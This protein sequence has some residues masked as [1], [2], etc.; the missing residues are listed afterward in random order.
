MTRPLP[1]ANLCAMRVKEV[2][3]SA[4]GIESDATL[5]DA[6]E[7]IQASGCEAVP[8]VEGS[9]GEVSVR[10]LVA[11]RDL[12]KLRRIEA[13]ASRGHAVGH[14]VLELLG[15]LG[16]RPGRFP[17]IEPEATLTDA[18]G[19]MSDECLTHLPVVEDGQV[20][21]M[22]SLV[23]TFAEFPHRSPAAGFWT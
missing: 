2:M 14:G 12:P 10:Q 19:I 16:R 3:R 9:N 17:T 13:S 23:V 15:A 22:V 5:A 18:W 1:S 7:A 21:G 4:R 20:V 8:V 11:L 6:A